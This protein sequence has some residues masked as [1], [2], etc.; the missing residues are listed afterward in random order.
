M[1]NLGMGK[2]CPVKLWSNVDYNPVIGY[3]PNLTV[4]AVDI[5]DTIFDNI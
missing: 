1:V 2:R 5:R 3:F 4:G